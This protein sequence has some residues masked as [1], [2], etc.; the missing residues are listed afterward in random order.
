ML[1]IEMIV[2]LVVEQNTMKAEM[3]QNHSLTQIAMHMHTFWFTTVVL[4]F[5]IL[6][7]LS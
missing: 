7:Q 2:S 6:T 4:S 1:R 3:P 5:K